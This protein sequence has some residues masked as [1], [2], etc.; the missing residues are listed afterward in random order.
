M[1]CNI[2]R[3]F[4]VVIRLNHE[5]S[6]NVVCVLSKTKL[7]ENNRN[8][9]QANGKSKQKK[10]NQANEINGEIDA[11]DNKIFSRKNDKLTF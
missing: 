10:T 6:M 8:I 1:M 4:H 2:D 9:V 7:K 5:C 11:N 3:I